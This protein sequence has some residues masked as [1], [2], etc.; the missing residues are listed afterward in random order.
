MNRQQIADKR[1]R[2]LHAQIAEKLRIHSELWA[3]PEEN[4]HRWERTMGGLSL[5]LYEWNQILHT[6]SKEK[7]L[8]LLES[9][10]EEAARLRSSSPFTGILSQSEREEILKA[11]KQKNRQDK[12]D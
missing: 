10:S 3:I 12:Q 9:P 8:S 11:F 4:I 6:Y 2:A 1:S 5:A 7:I